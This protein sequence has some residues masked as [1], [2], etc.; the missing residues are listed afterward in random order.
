MR[1][2]VKE[3]GRGG[4]LKHVIHSFIW[5]SQSLRG[6]QLAAYDPGKQILWS[7]TKVPLKAKTVNT[8]SALTVRWG[9]GGGSKVGRGGEGGVDHFWLL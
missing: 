4:P 3:G 7:R 8:D 9:D 2:G 1:E 5:R 6:R